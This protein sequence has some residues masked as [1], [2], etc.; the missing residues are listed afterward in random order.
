MS[1]LNSYNYTKPKNFINI[2]IGSVGKPGANLPQARTREQ[3]MTDQYLEQKVLSA[4]PEELTYMLYEGLVKFIK[5]ALIALDSKD[6]EKVHNNAMRANDIVGELRSTLNM[7]VGISD[8]L[9]RLYEY[10]EFKLVE[11]NVDKDKELFEDALS[12]AQEF[13]ETWREAFNL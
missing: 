1:V 4:K 13:K 8:N 9:D 3:E 6:Y 12:I 10:L 7:E 5:K 2:N 11:A